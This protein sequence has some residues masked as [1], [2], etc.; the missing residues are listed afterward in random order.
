MRRAGKADRQWAGST[1]APTPSLC[2]GFASPTDLRLSG[3]LISIGNSTGVGSI[4]KCESLIIPRD[5]TSEAPFG[6]DLSPPR[7][8]R[9][10][11]PL[12]HGRGPPAGRRDRRA[13][14]PSPL[15]DPP[16][17]GPEPL[18]RRRPRLL[19]LLP[20]ERPGP[21]PPTPAARSQAGRRRGVAHPRG[22]APGGRLVAAADRR[23]AQAGRGGR[24]ADGLPRDHPPPRPRAGGP[25]GRPLPPPA[26]CPPA[27]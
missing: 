25:R 17:A 11:H 19:R 10:P 4:A 7:P 27:A 6:P 9:T 20:P 8:R 21:R 14:R 12:P 16:G 1:Y 26:E 15:D 23:Q 24:W 5:C 13:A 22:R 3:E 2:S 18:P